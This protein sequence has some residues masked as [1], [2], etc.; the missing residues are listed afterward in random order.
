MRLSISNQVLSIKRWGSSV[1]RSN[2]RGFQFTVRQTS[3]DTGEVPK[4]KGMEGEDD[5]SFKNSKARFF[6]KGY[7]Q[8]EGSDF[9]EPCPP[10]AR[11]STTRILV[12]LAEQHGVQPV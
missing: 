1:K 3:L 5:E 9:L 10:K 6:A 4:V 8:V 11:I 7:S 2:E 12:N